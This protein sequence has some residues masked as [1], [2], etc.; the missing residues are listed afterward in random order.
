MKY[1]QPGKTAGFRREQLG[2]MRSILLFL[3]WQYGILFQFGGLAAKSASE[4]I[5]C[6]SDTCPNLS[7]MRKSK[8]CTLRPG[9]IIV[10][11][12]ALYGFRW[13]WTFSVGV[14]LYGFRLLHHFFTSLSDS[15][16]RYEEINGLLASFN[17]IAFDDLLTCEKRQWNMEN[18][19]WKVRQWRRIHRPRKYSK[20]D[21][22]FISG[23]CGG[24]GR[25][26][27]S[28]ELPRPA[29]WIWDLPRLFPLSL[30]VEDRPYIQ[31]I[32]P[33]CVFCFALGN[34]SAACPSQSLHWSLETMESDDESTKCFV[35]LRH[36]VISLNGHRRACAAASRI[37]RVSSPQHARNVTSR[38][39][40]AAS[41]SWRI[42]HAPES[43]CLPQMGI[44]SHSGL[45]A[46]G[47][48]EW[49]VCYALPYRLPHAAY[50]SYIIQSV[51]SAISF[52]STLKI[53]NCNSP[54]SRWHA[55]IQLAWN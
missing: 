42:S 8:F 51:L 50:F 43:L 47:D 40:I 6:I 32:C 38:G 36:I 49:R 3:H 53:L 33:I 30:D 22:D 13:Q 24:E 14:E 21:R 45:R 18:R 23:E 35:R 52:P 48:L 2:E 16:L 31:W 25:E 15:V 46:R 20:W 9:H 17:E 7:P 28:L 19:H 10:S 39:N 29:R 54:F 11:G 41:D 26:A 55:P 34:P 37:S 5:S 12:G 1:F 4:V 27:I 44:W